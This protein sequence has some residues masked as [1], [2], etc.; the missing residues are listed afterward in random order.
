MR[1]ATNP[2][3]PLLVT[4]EV[5]RVWQYVVHR[6]SSELLIRAQKGEFDR[7][8]RDYVF[9]SFGEMV[10]L[11]WGVN[12]VKIPRS[13]KPEIKAAGEVLYRLLNLCSE[14]WLLA[15]GQY[16]HPA[17]LF[18][19]LFGEWQAWGAIRIN[20]ANDKNFT[21]LHRRIQSENQQLANFEN[22]FTTSVTK[23]FFD[24]AIQMAEG[25]GRFLTQVY[26]P[27]IRARKAMAAAMPRG[28]GVGLLRTEAGGIKETQTRQKKGVQKATAEKRTAKGF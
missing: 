16:K 5:D 13:I 27:F 7:L 6:I 14:L 12:L 26:R 3:V 17:R 21:Q 22:P 23:E 1:N 25:K 15:P 9:L 2:A 20:I 10:R 24:V 4:G 8:V 18:G 19:D 11:K 28:E